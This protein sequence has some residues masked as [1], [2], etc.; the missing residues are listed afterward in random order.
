MH[1]MKEFH[2]ILRHLNNHACNLT[3]NNFGYKLIENMNGHEDCT[4]GKQKKKIRI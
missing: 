1:T 3:T 2:N 4:R